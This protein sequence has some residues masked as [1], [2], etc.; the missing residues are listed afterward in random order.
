MA[1]THDPKKWQTGLD[2]TSSSDPDVRAAGFVQLRD[3]EN[4][5]DGS[6]PGGAKPKPEGTTGQS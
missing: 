6:H 1:D 4:D 5:T 2:M 3:A